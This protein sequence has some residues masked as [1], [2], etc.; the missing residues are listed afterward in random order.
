MWQLNKGDD[1]FF[2]EFM[3]CW[4]PYDVVENVRPNLVE[5]VDWLLGGSTLHHFRDYLAR[6]E[7]WEDDELVEALRTQIRARNGVQS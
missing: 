3:A 2:H 7:Y 6:A 4:H 1:T 5:H